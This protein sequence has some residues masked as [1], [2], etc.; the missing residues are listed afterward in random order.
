MGFVTD[1]LNDYSSDNVGIIFGDG[2]PMILNYNLKCPISNPEDLNNNSMRCITG[3]YDINGP[4]SPNKLGVDIVGFNSSCS[5]DTGSTCYT[6]P[7][8]IKS[9][10]IETCVAMRKKANS[11]PCYD[12]DAFTGLIVQCGGIERVPSITKLAQLATYVYE[13]DKQNISLT[14]KQSLSNI[15]LNETYGLPPVTLCSSGANY[16]NQIFGCRSFSKNE[17]KYREIDRRY[18]GSLYGVCIA[19]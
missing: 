19:E 3:F 7:F 9:V 11:Y 6:K 5:I 15:K 16:N 8:K 14:Q 2:T 13:L 10:D 17:T 12:N 18:S 4:K 1:D